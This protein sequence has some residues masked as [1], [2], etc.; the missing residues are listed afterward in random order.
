MRLIR[1]AVCVALAGLAASGSLAL[2]AEAPKSSVTSKTLFLAQ[3][4]CGT[5]EEAGRLEPKAQTD[6]A[7]GCGTIG[8]L[9]FNEVLVQD[10]GAEAVAE[11]FTSTKA[12]VPVKI[13]HTKKVT[14]QVSAGS[15]IGNG[16][17]G[18]GTVKFTVGMV[19]KTTAGKT[20]D[21]GTVEV[22][23]AAAPGKDIVEVPFS[24]AIPATAKGAKLTTF[25]LS[26]AQHG[27]NLGMSS[28]SLSGTSYVVIPAKK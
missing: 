17:G 1:P 5:T 13:D 18:V 24:L 8:G 2:A 28:K 25:V 19:G 26:V 6:G 16:T 27:A 23:G 11:E 15:W 9:P 22:S 20:I 10:G 7:D 21:F 14:G 4:G 12:M 3:E